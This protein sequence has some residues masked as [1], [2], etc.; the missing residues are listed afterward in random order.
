LP[1]TG[2]AT[3][4]DSTQRAQLEGL[5]EAGSEVIRSLRL[6]ASGLGWYGYTGNTTATLD[7]NFKLTLQLASD[8]DPQ[9][10]TVAAFSDI[11]RGF[12]F[13]LGKNK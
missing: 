1:L 2:S 6:V 13:A 4:A 5:L 11:P 8:R 10:H 7:L 12:A 9:A 3:L